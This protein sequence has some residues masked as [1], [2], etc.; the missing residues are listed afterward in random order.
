MKSH[1][2]PRRTFLA[3]TAA[4]FASVLVLPRTVWGA[5]EKLNVGCVGCGGKGG[6]DIGAIGRGNNIVALC[7][8][9]EKKGGGMFKKHPNA[10]KFKDFRKMLDQVKEID[11][12]TVST[13]DHTHFP[14]SMCALMHG[15]HCFTQKPLTHNIWEAR[16]LAQVAREKK[17]ATQM[18]IQGHANEAARLVC[19]W[20]WAGLIGDVTEVHYWTNRPIWPQGIGRPKDTPPVPST[21]D[22]NLWLNVAPDRPYNPAYL[23]FKWR[24]WWDYGSGAIGDIACHVMDAGFWALDLRYPTSVSAE[25]SGVNDETFPKWSIITMEFPA[26]GNLKPCKVVWHDG[27]KMPPR[28][29]ELE[30]GRKMDKQCGAFFY[31]TKAAMMHNF[32]CSSA[33]I[34]PEAKHKELEPTKVPKTLP[35][36]PGTMNEYIEG[37]KRGDEAKG[38]NYQYAAALTEMAALGNLALRAGGGKKVEYDPKAMKVKNIPALNDYIKREPRKEYA[39][40]YKGDDVLPMP[41]VTGLGGQK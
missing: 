12:V 31:G 32:Y 9:D 1:L 35:R 33:R 41:A 19:E 30:E 11:A 8:V 24:G 25:S 34:I 36:S 2:V 15:K 21:L 13:P 37:C 17:L 7:E 26:R 23:P 4:G 10:K 20:V 39:E 40:F 38:A 29:K 3:G 16:R 6:S 27:G 22:W 18:G 28:P 5:N 14:A